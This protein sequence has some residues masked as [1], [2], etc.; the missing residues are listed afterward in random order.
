MTGQRTRSG[1]A[2]ALADRLVS[3]CALLAG[4]LI[5]LA[6]AVIFYE[7][8][9]RYLFGAPTTWSID[10]SS[11]LLLWATFLGSPYTLREGG[12]V[13]VDLLL[14]WLHGA[15]RRKIGLAIH[16]LVASFVAL[17][18]WQGALACVEAYRFGE[19]TMSVARFP[20]YLPL[21]AIPVGGS[22]LLLQALMLLA[23]DWRGGE[24]PPR[25]PGAP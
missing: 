9:A 21:L 13:A 7:V 23:D 11:Y 20:L 17:V 5:A 10:V 25:G 16:A 22:V 3:G 15:N 1:G 4:A 12:H 14:Q 18:V 6:C 24:D 2:R 19:V 8:A